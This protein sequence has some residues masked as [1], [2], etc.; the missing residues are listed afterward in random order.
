MGSINSNLRQST[1]AN[2]ELNLPN[3]VL[4][5]NHYIKFSIKMS[6]QND[7]IDGGDLSE[8][9]SVVSITN[10]HF[11]IESQN[12][13]S[14][15][16]TVS[17]AQP[18]PNLQQQKRQLRQ[19]VEKTVKYTSPICC[20]DLGP[21]ASGASKSFARDIFEKVFL[22]TPRITEEEITLFLLLND[23]NDE[24]DQ[25]GN[26]Y[27]FLS[28]RDVVENVEYK[29]AICCFKLRQE[30]L[31]RDYW[32]FFRRC[33]CFQPVVFNKIYALFDVRKYRRCLNKDEEVEMEAAGDE[34]HFENRCQND[35]G[36]QNCTPL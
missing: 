9:S 6:G 32:D 23:A 12:Y 25:S 28:V 26:S 7:T 15:T 19:I 27:D 17:Y 11:D 21:I 33:F 35:D 29:S 30:D 36:K 4:E 31:Q 1:V 20:F 5:E 18:K 2:R 16:S 24:N 22:Y 10:E 8:K 3:F 34:E 14:T 13:Q